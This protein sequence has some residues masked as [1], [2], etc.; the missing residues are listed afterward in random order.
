MIR[1][2]IYSSKQIQGSIFFVDPLPLLFKPEHSD[3]IGH[4]FFD[5]KSKD[6]GWKEKEEE[7]EGKK[8]TIDMFENVSSWRDG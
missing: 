2:F 3:R 5:R 4:F 6:W 1:L 7:E 8:E